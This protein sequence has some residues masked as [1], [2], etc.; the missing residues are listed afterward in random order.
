LARFAV[1]LPPARP[2]AGDA[3]VIGI[4]IGCGGGASAGLV[5]CNKASRATNTRFGVIIPPR[6]CWTGNAHPLS[7]IPETRSSACNALVICS[8][9]G[10]FGRADTAE[11]RRFQ[12]VGV[13]T[14][15]LVGSSQVSELFCIECHE[16]ES[17]EKGDLHHKDISILNYE[18]I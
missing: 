11:L 8:H 2:V 7:G 10:S 14:A 13:R 18:H 9:E 16:E 3:F 12:D 17:N 1:F 15:S 5:D 4:E 6:V